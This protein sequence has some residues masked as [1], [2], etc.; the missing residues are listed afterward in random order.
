MGRAERWFPRLTGAG[1]AGG[2][3][4]A[5]VAVA[6][7]W[8]PASARGFDSSVTIYP[9]W[10]WALLIG[11]LACGSV[12]A[13]VPAGRPGRVWRLA[14]AG[15]AF[16]LGAEVAGTGV[17]AAK[18]WRPAQGM[19]GYPGDTDH[20]ELLAV[21]VAAGGLGVVVLALVQLLVDGAVHRVSRPAW[22][23]AHVATGVAIVALLPVLVSSTTVNPP[24]LTPWGAV[25]L[26]YAGPWGATAALAAW[27]TRSAALAALTTVVACAVL[28]AVGP[29]MR[30]LVYGADER[31]FTITAV[32][33]AALGAA[34]VGRHAGG[35]RAT[36]TGG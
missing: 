22:S 15:A 23:A 11:G 16:A 27:W 26:I 12:V 21:A 9:W 30:G 7:P 10:T 28:A 24:D 18:H 32:A 2:F 1:I 19:G 33:V 14:G 3:L 34:V 4:V 8:A 6:R 31:A 20:L 5:A 17:V 13:L 35:T 36:G 25:G 29:Q